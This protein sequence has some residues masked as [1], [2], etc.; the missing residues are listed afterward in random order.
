MDALTTD[1]SGSLKHWENVLKGMRVSIQENIALNCIGYIP[2]PFPDLTGLRSRAKEASN[3]FT[4]TKSPTHHVSTITSTRTAYSSIVAKAKTLQTSPLA[5]VQAAWASL[6]L[7]YSSEQEDG[8]DVVFGSVIGGRT[9]E[10]LERTAAPLFTAVPIRFSTTSS[11][12]INAS[13]SLGAVLEEL[14]SANA[15][16]L[17]Y[18]Y[19]PTSVLTRGGRGAGIIYDTTIALQTFSQG[20]SQTDLWTDAAY[21]PMT[22]EVLIFSSV[23]FNLR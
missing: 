10:A 7:C 5:I 23:S 4:L 11:S 20:T 17:K 18:R 21:P 8:K 19:P 3:K 9:T 14:T 15:T 1:Q 2:D 22:T 16:A 12:G 6:L 13:R